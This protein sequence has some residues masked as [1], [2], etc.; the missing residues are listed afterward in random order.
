MNRPVTS[1]GLA[2]EA[3]WHMGN[4]AAADGGRADAAAFGVWAV[5]VHRRAPGKS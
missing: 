4:A 2:S 1:N 5:G 3:A